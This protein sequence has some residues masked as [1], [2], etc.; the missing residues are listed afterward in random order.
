MSMYNLLEYS[1]IYFNTA[2]SLWFYSRNKKTSF[3]AAIVKTTA[4]K[5][6]EYKTKLV[7]ETII[8]PEPNIN[9]TILKNAMIALSLKCLI[10]SKL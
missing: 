9:S 2:G 1:S 7:G 8:Q 4:F 10:Y 5:F 3:N 6:L